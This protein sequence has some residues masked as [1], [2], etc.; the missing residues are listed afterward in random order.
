[1]T[2]TG[3]FGVVVAAFTIAALVVGFAPALSAAMIC[4]MGWA[5]FKGE[6]WDADI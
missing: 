2:K 4:V 6:L 3:Y 5:T 1:M